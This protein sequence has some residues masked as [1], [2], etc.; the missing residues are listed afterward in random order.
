[1]TLRPLRKAGLSPKFVFGFGN[2]MGRTAAGSGW[3]WGTGITCAHSCLLCFGFAKQGHQITF[4]FSFF[5]SE[6]GAR[7]YLVFREEIL[8]ANPS[9]TPL[10]AF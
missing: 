5:F 8:I 2:G 1:M 9:P 3:I 4:P 7:E 10:F 6:L